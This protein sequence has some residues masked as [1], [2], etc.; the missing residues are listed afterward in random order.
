MKL[1]YYLKKELSKKVSFGSKITYQEFQELYKPYSHLLPELIFATEVMDIKPATFHSHQYGENLTIKPFFN[2]DEETKSRLIKELEQKYSN[3][4][5]TYDTFTSI[6]KDFSHMVEEKTFAKEIFDI[7]EDFFYRFKKGKYKARVFTDKNVFFSYYGELYD[8]LYKLYSK[9]SV[10]YKRFLELYEFHAP[11]LSETDFA[12]CLGLNFSK[13]RSIKKCRNKGANGNGY[14]TKLFVFPKADFSSINTQKLEEEYRNKSI[15]YPE[16]KDIYE[17]YGTKL[18]EENFA[19]LLGISISTFNNFRLKDNINLNILKKKL[20]PEETRK[21]I[22]ECRERG[23]T[24]RFITVEEFYYYYEPYKESININDFGFAIGITSKKIARIKSGVK[25][26]AL[27]FEYD[28]EYKKMIKND[29]IYMHY[30]SINYEQFMSLYSNYSTYISETEF[31][32]L[33]GI[34]LN[35]FYYIKKNLSERALIDFYKPERKIIKHQLSDSKFYTYEELKNLADMVDLDLFSLLLLYFGD[36]LSEIAYKYYCALEKNKGLFLGSTSL[37]SSERS[38]EILTFCHNNARAACLINRCAYLIEDIE[39]EM[40]NFIYENCGSYRINFG[41]EW[42]EFISPYLVGIMK[43]RCQIIKANNVLSLDK[44]AV[45]SFSKE[46]NLYSYI[47][48][49]NEN[50][51]NYEIENITNDKYYN[52]IISLISKGLDPIE[53]AQIMGNKYSTSPEKVLNHIKKFLEEND[54]TR[55]DKNG[56]VTLKK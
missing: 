36:D 4:E 13:Y 21:I 24:R 50:E 19:R 33:L 10:N 14:Q 52:E 8:E 54:F 56:N 46:G 17:K 30:H 47:A 29:L 39:E 44:H 2:F 18:S 25:T 55:T 11:F 48:S 23:L 12:L 42:L 28:I 41:D 35:R 40:I 1:I 32:H 9:E 26:M 45:T 16:F 38:E 5:I 6:Y 37:Q 43:K 7:N 51:F 3:S 34:S 15:N 49:P 20:S 53:A 27:D 22:A 31:A